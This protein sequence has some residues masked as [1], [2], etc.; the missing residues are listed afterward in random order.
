MTFCSSLTLV[1]FSASVTLSTFSHFVSPPNILS[2]FLPLLHFPSIIPVVTRC[3]R[4][5]LLITWLKMLAIYVFYIWV[6]LLCRLH[7]RLF[8]LISLQSMRFVAFSEGTLYTDNEHKSLVAQICGQRLTLIETFT[9][10]FF[11]IVMSKSKESYLS[12]NI[13]TTTNYIFQNSGRFYT[14]GLKY[15]HIK[16]NAFLLELLY[17]FPL[18]ICIIQVIW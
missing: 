18:V 4:F 13:S 11:E 6:I 3:S 14:F 17:Y 7:V 16:D 15:T 8:C 9:W 1:A 2:C 10:Y 5:S 12:S